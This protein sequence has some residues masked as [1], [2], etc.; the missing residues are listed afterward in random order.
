M[1]EG[2]RAAPGRRV[3]LGLSGGCYDYDLSLRRTWPRRRGSRRI[4]C[5]RATRAPP[6]TRARAPTDH[7]YQARSEGQRRY[8]THIM[9]GQRAHVSS[10]R[11][12]LS[13]SR[14]TVMPTTLAPVVFAMR[15]AAV[16]QPH[17]GLARLAH[18]RTRQRSAVADKQP[19]QSNRR[20]RSRVSRRRIC[21]SARTPPCARCTLRTARSS[22]PCGRTAHPPPEL[23]SA[24]CARKT[25]ASDQVGSDRGKGVG[26]TPPGASSRCGRRHRL[27]TSACA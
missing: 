15:I 12:S 26:L 20:A 22:Q 2:S 14:E 10:A 8:V 4:R 9:G 24:V 16:H 6:T 27:G 1:V 3:S 7:A 23:P 5:A 13:C 11:T 25:P 21:G 18:L 19:D 17:P